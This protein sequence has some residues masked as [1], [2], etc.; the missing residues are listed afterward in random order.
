MAHAQHT[1]TRPQVHEYQDYRLLLRDWLKFLK[2]SPEGI[3]LRSLAKEC[4][5]SASNL[6]MILSGSRK[7]SVALFEQLAPRLGLSPSEQS[8]VKVLLV[9]SDSQ[10]L[11]SGADAFDRLNR[12]KKFQ[13]KNPAEFEVFRYLTHWYY[14][15]I[16]EMTALPEFKLDA[17]WI[18]SRLGGEISVRE[19]ERALKFLLE[20]HYIETRADGSVRP[21]ERPIE[22]KGE[23]FRLAL[24]KYHREL[25]KLGMSSLDDVPSDQRQL[26]GFTLAV[27]QNYFGKVSN[28][29]KKAYDDIMALAQEPKSSDRVVHVEMALFP[30]TKAKK[31]Q[32]GSAK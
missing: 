26:L 22:C 24:S 5:V 12:F 8:Y 19:I 16:R 4:Q 13:R 17:R 27:D 15:A 31:K 10:N 28:I 14:V 6:S 32:E 2:T 30:V 25:L 18:Q 29:L 1:R 20:Y 9:L 21:P 3:T 7:L 11:S 23:V